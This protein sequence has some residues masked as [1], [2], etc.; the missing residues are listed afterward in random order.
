LVAPEEE[1][2]EEFEPTEEKVEEFETVEEEGEPEEVEEFEGFDESAPD[3][4]TSSGY[5]TKGGEIPDYEPTVDEVLSY[6]MGKTKDPS[7][8]APSTMELEMD[9]GDA[10]PEGIDE[11][12]DELLGEVSSSKEPGAEEPL[13]EIEGLDDAFADDDDDVDDDDDDDHDDDDDDEV[14]DD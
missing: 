3:E 5:K 9:D 2:E 1:E 10:L 13:Q 8:P 12:L 6:A 4:I 11:A 14:E 7:Q